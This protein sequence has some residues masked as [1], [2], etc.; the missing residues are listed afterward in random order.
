MLPLWSSPPWRAQA[1]CE[2]AQTPETEQ[3][4]SKHEEGA[5]QTSKNAERLSALCVCAVICASLP[6]WDCSD[7]PP[8]LLQLGKML[9]WPKPG[10][11]HP[12][13]TSFMEEK[14]A[15]GEM[16]WNKYI[17]H[18]RSRSIIWSGS[19]LSLVRG[20]LQHEGH[21]HQSIV[22]L[23]LKQHLQQEDNGS[24]HMRCKTPGA[25]N[26]I[27]WNT[28]DALKETRTE[29]G[30]AE[31]GGEFDFIQPQISCFPLNA[32]D[33]GHK[34]TCWWSLCLKVHQVLFQIG[35]GGQIGGAASIKLV[36]HLTGQQAKRLIYEILKVLFLQA[37]FV[38]RFSEA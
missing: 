12:V 26:L 33:P 35:Q 22:I 19:L 30:E 16:L 20:S 25:I 9:S 21:F 29:K 28:P 38:A 8:G 18:D 24:V 11:Q 32:G 4:L 27:Y 14:E 10:D 34:H 31:S 13:N 5:C 2:A 23:K 36:L 7:C 15:R 6:L 17:I 1:L 37:L 3:N